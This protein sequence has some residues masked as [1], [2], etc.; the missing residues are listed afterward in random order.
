MVLPSTLFS[1]DH[2][3]ILGKLITHPA[4]VKTETAMRYGLTWKTD[5]EVNILYSGEHKPIN[6]FITEVTTIVEVI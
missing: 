1:N 6:E 2:I 5:S 3:E 4:S